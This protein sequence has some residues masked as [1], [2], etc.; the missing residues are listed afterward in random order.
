VKSGAAADRETAM[1]YVQAGDWVKLREWL[2]SPDPYRGTPTRDVNQCGN[3]GITLLH[4]ASGFGQLNIIDGLID[5]IHADINAKDNTGLTP[6]H[7]A[8]NDGYPVAARALLEAG[9]DLSAINTDTEI[10]LNGGLP[11]C[12]PGGRTPL[13]LAA[14][15]GQ[16]DCVRLLLTCVDIKTDM[17]DNDGNTPAQLAALSGYDDLAKLLDAN[18]TLVSQP[19]IHRIILLHHINLY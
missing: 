4:V 17:K 9:A 14:D 3:D 5:E 19:L 12:Q 15:R 2:L 1:E 8:C 11:I 6:L 7:L 10:R 13:H 18:V 16:T